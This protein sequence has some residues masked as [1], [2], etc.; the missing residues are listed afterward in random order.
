MSKSLSFGCIVTCWKISRCISHVKSFSM[1]P[2]LP[3]CRQRVAGTARLCVNSLCAHHRP[4]YN[5]STCDHRCP[6]QPSL[7][8]YTIRH[9]RLLSSAS[10]VARD[11]RCPQLKYPSS[12][13][14]VARDSRCLRLK[15]PSPATLVVNDQCLSPVTTV[16]RDRQDCYRQRCHRRP[17]FLLTTFSLRSPRQPWRRYTNHVWMTKNDTPS[18][19][20][21]PVAWEEGGSRIALEGEDEKMTHLRRSGSPPLFTWESK[22]LD[23]S[24]ST[25]SLLEDLDL[26][27]FSTTTFLFKDLECR[28]NSSQI[29]SSPEQFL[30]SYYYCRTKPESTL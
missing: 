7:T 20:R 5:V 28:S 11:Y 4:Q 1:I 23:F 30:L 9:L 3:I 18:P 29:F 2:N 26:N 24:F 17:R 27:F 16:A 6:W 22:H 10:L 14:I 25:T 21:E 19:L 12:T 13:I 8:T 15:K